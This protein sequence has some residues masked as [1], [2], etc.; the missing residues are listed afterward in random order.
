MGFPPP[1]FAA[2]IRPSLTFR[3]GP[4]TGRLWI[5]PSIPQAHASMAAMFLRAGT[6][7]SWPSATTAQ[8]GLD[9]RWSVRVGK[10]DANERQMVRALAAGHGAIPPDCRLAQVLRRAGLLV[11]TVPADLS[12]DSL[13]WSQVSE[14]GRGDIHLAR[15]GAAHVQVD[16]LGFTGA[17]LCAALADARVG[18]ISSPDT[19]LITVAD[20]AAGPLR[21]TVGQR[22]YDVVA[23][24]L[25]RGLA[26]EAGAI[27]VLVHITGYAVDPAL[28]AQLVNEG[29]THMPIVFS[30]TAVTVG[31]VVRPGHSPCLGCLDRH[32]VQRDARWPHVA[33]GI[34]RQAWL[35]EPSL[36]LWATAAAA[37]MVLAVLDRRERT[38]VSLTCHLDD[39]I[40]QIGT[41]EHHPRCGCSR[42]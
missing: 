3:A 29:I 2:R 23:R 37:A 24:R 22:R 19:S 14:V 25:P 36:A 30:D 11:D 34:S 16:D 35:E 26:S 6:V 10:L 21:G 20:A 28:S 4:H 40:P 41:W 8:F 12:P 13:M 38:G 39:P 32:R 15:R 18:A 17:S 33:A 1:V 9:P 5:T 27:D 31:P 7:V 42:L